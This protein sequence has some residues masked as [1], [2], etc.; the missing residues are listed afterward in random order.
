MALSL[1]LRVISRCIILAVTLAAMART[2]AC[3][4]ADLFPFVIRSDEAIHGTATDMSFLNAVPAGCHGAIVAKDGHFV[5]SSTKQ[6]VRFLG[7]NITGKCAFPSHDLAQG[8]AKHLAKMGVNIVRIHLQDLNYSPLWKQQ[9]LEHVEFDPDA[10]D[11]LDYFL[12]QLKVNGIYVDLNLHSGREFTAANGFPQSVEHLPDH[13]DKRID[14]VDERMILLQM[15]FAKDYLTHTN[16]YTKL[17]YANDPFVAIVE[18][19]NEDSLLSWFPGG[20]NGYFRQLPEPFRSQCIARWNEWLVGKYGDTRRLRLAWAPRSDIAREMILPGTAA[21]SM[22]DRINAGSM[23]A[24]EHGVD[25]SISKAG[26]NTWDV[27][28]HLREFPLVDN[29]TYTVSFR[30]KADTPRSIPV[31][32]G[33]GL[34]GRHSGLETYASLT[35]DWQT[36]SMPFVTFNPDP[37]SNRLSFCLAGT[38]GTVSISDVALCAGGEVFPASQSLE[39]Q[40]VEIP[41]VLNHVQK[42]DWIEFLSS[43]EVSYGDRMRYY[44]RHD[45]GVRA[46]I[47]D[48]QIGYGGAASLL[49]EH[50]SDFA[51]T[52]GYSGR[53]PKSAGDQPLNGTNWTIPNTPLVD[54]LAAGQW[55][56]LRA[57]VENRIDG[58]PF[59]VSEWNHPAPSDYQA[60][61]IPLLASFGAL[62]DW[63]GIEWFAYDIAN[64]PVNNYWFGMAGNPSKEAFFP[65]AAAIFRMAE[66]APAPYAAIMKLTP[67]SLLSGQSISDLWNST[68]DDKRLDVLT[69][70]FSLIVDRSVRGNSIVQRSAPAHFDTD[71]VRIENTPFGPIYA[72]S[73]QAALAVS[74]FVGGQT[75][76]RGGVTMKFPTFGNNFA[77]LTLTTIDGMPISASKRM[78]LTIVGH[79]E[80]EGMIWNATRTSVGRN[81]GHGPDLAEGIAAN[82]TLANP[83]VKHVWA[84]DP[85]GSR[86]KELPIKLSDGK[87]SFTVGPGYQTV[88]Y[89]VG[90]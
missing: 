48:T 53:H 86:S 47:I 37:L 7:V 88:W 34:T 15:Q 51:D 65:A 71:S 19:N 23:T 20:A 72:A 79:V 45:L 11:R 16:P 55:E 52:H 50:D 58:K 39:A 85:A 36:F 46:N 13:Y 31:Y 78:L 9:S 54:D 66:I 5:E 69:T 61:T 75:I 1:P 77:S 63:D 80:K 60:E 30:A 14:M 64:G 42:A 27:Q 67:E 81:W 25:V 29:A 35:P 82:I 70:R 76:E 59:T 22:E 68:L 4:S 12:C 87:A 2:G 32:I 40:T 41:K 17:S 44:L 89:E 49:L 6:R 26:A 24:R 21:W 83:A 57:M 56:A 43:L 28:A 10:L 74:G 90:G 62:Q 38:T 73:G 18:I 8:V 33:S 3:A 84:L